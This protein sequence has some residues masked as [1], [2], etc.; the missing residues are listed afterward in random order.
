MSWLAWNSEAA[1][2]WK[3][4]L[5]PLCSIGEPFLVQY[6]FYMPYQN[7]QQARALEPWSQPRI[8]VGKEVE[9]KDLLKGERALSIPLLLLSPH[10]RRALS[11][12]LLYLSEGY[13]SAC[14]FARSLAWPS[15]WVCCLPRRCPTVTQS[16]RQR[17]SSLSS[18]FLLPW[19]GGRRRGRKERFQ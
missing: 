10:K 7:S 16:W 6:T 9:K 17:P 8:P 11:R 4:P 2:K 1:E 13:R 12:F 3:G 19:A 18:P 14:S 15:V 5:F